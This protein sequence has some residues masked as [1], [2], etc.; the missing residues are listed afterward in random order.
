MMMKWLKSACVA[1]P[2][3]V[4]SSVATAQTSQNQIAASVSVAS[5]W[6]WRGLSQTEGGPALIGER[7]QAD[8]RRWYAH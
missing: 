1:L 4:C 5:D 6:V 7:W 2:I 8:N 3:F